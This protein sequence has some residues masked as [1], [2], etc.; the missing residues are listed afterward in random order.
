MDGRLDSDAAEPLVFSYILF[1]LSHCLL[2]HPFLLRQRLEEYNANIPAKFLAR[3]IAICLQHAQDLTRVLREA[4]KA[5]CKLNSSF[6]SFAVVVAGMISALHR[7]SDDELVRR[8]AIDDLQFNQ[9]FLEEHAKYWKNS[10]II[11]CEE[12]NP[13]T[14]ETNAGLQKNALSD[15]SLESSKFKA[16][17]EAEPQRVQL[18][19]SD[20]EKLYFL[21]DYNTLSRPGDNPSPVLR[22]TRPDPPI[23][24]P[25]APPTQ[26]LSHSAPHPHDFMMQN[27]VLFGSP[28]NMPPG[29]IGNLNFIPDFYK[30]DEFGGIDPGKWPNG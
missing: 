1:H 2:H 20:A 28:P 3:S 4:Q 5:G 7:H 21:T 30:V 24:Y 19:P 6:Y 17:I 27:S 12:V 11:V 15:F 29:S 9:A 18:D 22:N 14:R 26:Q 8:Q 23:L 16:L 13:P 25:D 10:N